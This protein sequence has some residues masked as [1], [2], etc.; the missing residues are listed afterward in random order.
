MEQIHGKVFNTSF[1]L[2]E[3]LG[4]KLLSFYAEEKKNIYYEEMQTVLSN[5]LLVYK[6]KCSYYIRD[7]FSGR[8]TYK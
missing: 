7:T 3:T 4:L 6:R 1:A 5:V 8:K 2:F